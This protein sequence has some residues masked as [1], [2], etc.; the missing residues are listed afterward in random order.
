[1]SRNTVLILLLLVLLVSLVAFIVYGCMNMKTEHFT[2]TTDDKKEENKEEVKTETSDL[3]PK[4]QELFEDLKDNKLS[5]EQITELVKGGVLTEA[6]VEKFLLQ[7]DA[8]V[9]TVSNT[10]EK[11][12]EKEDFIEGFTSTG[13]RYACASF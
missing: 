2:T 10:D 7:L 12:E 1:M 11:N 4:E 8:P 9:D 5:T 13:N 6:L 3:S